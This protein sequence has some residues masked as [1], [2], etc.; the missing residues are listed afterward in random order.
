MERS[1]GVLL[2]TLALKKGKALEEIK[3]QKTKKKH[4]IL[5]LV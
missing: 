1:I 5:G 2:F 3:S 4:A